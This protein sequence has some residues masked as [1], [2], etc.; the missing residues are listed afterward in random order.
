[1]MNKGLE[2]IEASWIFGVEADRIEVLIH[3]ESVI[4]SMVQYEDGAVLAEMGNPDMRTPIAHALAYPERI[5]SGVE[6]LDLVKIAG[7]SFEAPDFARFPCLPL[8]Y[9]ALRAGGS[10]PAVLNAANEEAVAAFL[11][12]VL[13]FDQISGVVAK[14]L[15]AIP[16]TPLA[17][18][19]DVL[20]ADF[21]ARTFAKE[22]LLRNSVAFA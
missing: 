11:N 22:L 7:L 10:A 20:A 6:S 16:F 15:E 4:H 13:R 5:A 17:S 3:P 8:A 1:M 2:V 12:G 21:S 19:G 18:L 9:D 14:T